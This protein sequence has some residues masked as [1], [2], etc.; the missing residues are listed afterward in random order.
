MLQIYGGV[1]SYGFPTLFFSVTN[2]PISPLGWT[3]D[4]FLVKQGVN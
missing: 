3:N 1:L 2:V 4:R